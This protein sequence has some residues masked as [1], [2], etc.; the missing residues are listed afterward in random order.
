MI[1]QRLLVKAAATICLLV[2]VSRYGML[3]G[4][5]QIV[6]VEADLSIPV[7]E[8]QHWH[9]RWDEHLGDLGPREAGHR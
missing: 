8:Q 6:E 5:H 3:D 1:A 7:A 4:E 9:M 2:H